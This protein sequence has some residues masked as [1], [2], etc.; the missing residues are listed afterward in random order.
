[1]EG[2]AFAKWNQKSNPKNHELFQKFQSHYPRLWIQDHIR[3]KTL[4]LQFQISDSTFFLP[5]SYF[6]G[7]Y[8]LVFNF[9]PCFFNPITQRIGTLHK[10]ITSG[11]RLYI[12]WVFII[13]GKLKSLDNFTISMDVSNTRI[14]SL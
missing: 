9:I 4:G 6:E 8:G 7:S 10:R 12:F 1:M 13:T 3:N 2:R 11:P 5:L 14:Q